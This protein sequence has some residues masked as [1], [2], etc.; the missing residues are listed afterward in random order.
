MLLSLTVQMYKLYFSMGAVFLM[1][2]LH[3]QLASFD[4]QLPQCPMGDLCSYKFF[5]GMRE[6][7][8]AMNRKRAA[9]RR[10]ICGRH[11]SGAVDASKSD[12][13]GMAEHCALCLGTTKPTRCSTASPCLQLPEERWAA[14]E[15][16]FTTAFCHL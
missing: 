1:M 14:A 8:A 12:L 15:A 13:L 3:L 9:R 16:V 5:R 7:R 11:T 4:K 6:V 2:D 10:C